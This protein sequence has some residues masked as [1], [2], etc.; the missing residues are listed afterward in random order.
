MW[1]AFA[2]LS[3]LTYSSAKFA[4]SVYFSISMKFVDCAVFNWISSNSYY[5]IIHDFVHAASE[6]CSA[7]YKPQVLPCSKFYLIL[8]TANSQ[9]S[10]HHFKINSCSYSSMVPFSICLIYMA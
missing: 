3:C 5:N 2:A 8:V 1:L 4:F 7:L 10:I 9:F 6:Q